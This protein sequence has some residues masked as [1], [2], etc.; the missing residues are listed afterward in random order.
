MVRGAW[1]PTVHGTERLTLFTVTSDTLMFLKQFSHVL[2]WGT[3][4]AD[5]ELMFWSS[6][7]FIHIH[8][9]THAHTHI[10]TYTYTH[11]CTHTYIHSYSHT[12]THGP[13]YKGKVFYILNVCTSCCSL[14][15]SPSLAPDFLIT[16]TQFRD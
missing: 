11:T 8:I 13:R 7:Y 1:W 3:R 16:D 9:H 4:L 10:Y 12:Y 5:S 6:V 15:H 14:I 2:S